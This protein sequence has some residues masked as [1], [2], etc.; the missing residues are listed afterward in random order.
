M[1]LLITTRAN[2]HKS[3]V[4]CTVRRVLHQ[5]SPLILRT[6]SGGRALI[7]LTLQMKKG[8]VRDQAT[9]PRL[10]SED[11]VRRSSTQAADMGG[12]ARKPLCQVLKATWEAGWA[13]VDSSP[14]LQLRERKH[15]GLGDISAHRT[16][17]PALT[18]GRTGG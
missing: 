3:C 7:I 11:V 8:G 17:P 16:N 15:R 10:G 18:N 12:H 4:P 5:L 9:C 2:I 13:G 14:F 1:R 6:I